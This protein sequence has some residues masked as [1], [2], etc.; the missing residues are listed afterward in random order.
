MQKP[1]NLLV[2]SPDPLDPTSFHRAWGPLLTLEKQMPNLRLLQCGTQ[3][4]DFN[5]STFKRADIAL[6]QRPA[7]AVHAKL[8]ELAK[9]HQVPVWVD[10]DDDLFNVPKDNK[11]ST[12]Y[13]DELKKYIQYSLNQAD[14]TTVTSEHLKACLSQ[15]SSNIQV[16]PNAY[17]DHWLQKSTPLSPPRKFIAWRGDERHQ[18][19][20]HDFK[21]AFIDASN[22]HPDWT[23]FFIGYNPFFITEKMRDGSWNYVPPMPILTFM[24]WMKNLQAGITVVPMRDRTFNHAKSNVGWIQ[25]TYAG[26]TILGPHWEQW[27]RPGITNYFDPQD[28]KAKL[29]DM[30]AG[31]VDLHEEHQKSWSFIKDNLMLSTVNKQR[32]SLIE[33][34]A[35]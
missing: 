19:D 5:W 32:Q 31:S 33:Q 12:V 21:D 15:M 23:F 34:Y 7:S 4:S 18:A 24:N 30:M 29:Y 2:V 11:S 16:I 6:F 26:S 10:Y 13:N 25:A 27:Q 8:I 9:E 1:I 14:I 17:D 20:L 28:F 22:D 35:R 3:Y